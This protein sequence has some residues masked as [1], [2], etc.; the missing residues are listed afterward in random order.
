[1]RNVLLGRRFVSERVRRRLDTRFPL[2]K[3]VIRHARQIRKRIRFHLVGEA[4]L[5]GNRP[6]SV[7]SSAFELLE[8]RFDNM[9]STTMMMKSVAHVQVWLGVPPSACSESPE[10]FD[11][12]QGQSCTG[13][14]R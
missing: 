10:C 2:S 3:G 14:L 5:S 12:V 4:F 8:R 6:A 13:Y 7:R 9:A 1:M 11:K